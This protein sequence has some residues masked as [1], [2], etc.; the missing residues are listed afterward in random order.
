MPGRPSAQKLLSVAVLTW[1]LFVLFWLAYLVGLIRP[2]RSLFLRKQV[3]IPLTTCL[4]S[5]EDGT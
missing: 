4:G 1:H 3:W 5:V 2:T